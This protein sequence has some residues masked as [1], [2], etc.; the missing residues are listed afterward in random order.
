MIFGIIHFFSL[1]AI[2]SRSS[3]S[4]I[5]YIKC[6][7]Q[8]YIPGVSQSKVLQ[9]SAGS[10][11]EFLRRGFTTIKIIGRECKNKKVLPGSVTIKSTVRECHNQ[12][13]CQE[14]SKSKEHQES[15]TIKS[16]SRKCHNQKFCQRV[17]QSWV[18]PGSTT[19]SAS[20]EWLN[21]IYC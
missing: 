10:D 19:K 13:N 1:P 11:L 17:P 12:K 20:R 14:V 21:Q 16:T 8:K 5:L 18:L 15:A 4:S 9:G 2:I 3:E 7:N 6:H